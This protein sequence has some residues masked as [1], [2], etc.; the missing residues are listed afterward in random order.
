MLPTP[1]RSQERRPSR[2]V[3]EAGRAGG[4]ED[5]GAQGLCVQE[6]L[7]WGLPLTAPDLPVGEARQMLGRHP[8]GP[9]LLPTV[10]GYSAIATGSSSVS[11]WPPSSPEPGLPPALREAGR[12]L[13]RL[14]H[15]WSADRKDR[16]T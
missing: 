3:G 8:L 9:L 13:A 16:V 1:K 4:E 12:W 6:A 11:P 2:P 15:S 5:R 10:P 7:E 14:S